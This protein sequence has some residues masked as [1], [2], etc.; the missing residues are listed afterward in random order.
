[1]RSHVSKNAELNRIQTWKIWPQNPIHLAL[2]SQK[3]DCCSL[4]P[5]Q[6]AYFCLGA[7]LTLLCSYQIPWLPTH[8]SDNPWSAP[9]ERGPC[10]ST[11]EDRWIT[12]PG[13]SRTW[14]VADNYFWEEH[15]AHR[16]NVD[17]CLLSLSRERDRQKSAIRVVPRDQRRK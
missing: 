1:M 5:H 4:W 7:S 3:G 17:S 10:V 12:R 13:S 16:P 6:P 2:R 9:T 11:L 15:K 8:S 14:E